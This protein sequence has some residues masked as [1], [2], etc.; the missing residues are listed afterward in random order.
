MHFAR[1]AGH[2]GAERGQTDGLSSKHA[3]FQESRWVYL[4][5]KQIPHD[6]ESMLTEAAPVSSNIVEI[7]AVLPEFGRKPL[8][9]I[10]QTIEL[11]RRG[12][13]QTFFPGSRLQTGFWLLAAEAGF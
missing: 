3:D 4:F 7:G 13:A 5:E 9:K 8:I 1:L 6:V 10:A 12:F 2:P 11:K